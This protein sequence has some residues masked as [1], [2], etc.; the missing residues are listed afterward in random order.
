MAN[1]IPVAQ[2]SLI[3]LRLRSPTAL[4]NVGSW[5][6]V[7]ACLP[8]W[9]LEIAGTMVKDFVEMFALSFI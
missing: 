4:S 7:T 2:T 1:R 6:A 5:L 8:F 3:G 9:N